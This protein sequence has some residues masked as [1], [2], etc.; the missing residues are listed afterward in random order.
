LGFT[1][2]RVPDDTESDSFLVLPIN[3]IMLGRGEEMDGFLAGAGAGG[4]EG[5][6]DAETEPD[7]FR[8]IAK[9]ATSGN[10]TFTIGI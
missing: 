3:P 4:T 5:L 10:G 2:L 8:R 6:V 1:S 7:L 9:V